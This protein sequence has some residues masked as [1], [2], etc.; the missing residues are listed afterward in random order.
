MGQCTS[1]RASKRHEFNKSIKELSSKKVWM[2]V[3]IE[4]F[5]AL[6][7]STTDSQKDI[8]KMRRQFLCQ[9][10]LLKEII[11]D[12]LKLQSN[13]TEALKLRVQQLETAF[14]ASA[15]A[16]PSS[17]LAVSTVSENNKHFV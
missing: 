12:M 9:S 10:T 4:E 8:E 7:K 17:T 5:E 13:E 6:Q 15:L 16:Q 3:K 11:D 1:R 2:M 14:A